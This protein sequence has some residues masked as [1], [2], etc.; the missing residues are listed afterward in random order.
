M[1]FYS[2]SYSEALDLPLRTFWLMSNNIN[3]ISAE[4]D[5]RR[6]S[7]MAAASSSEGFGKAQ[8]ALQREM[9]EVFGRAAADTSDLPSEMEIRRGLAT[10]KSL[11]GKM[12]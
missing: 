2:M 1:H 4:A 3:R 12:T 5:I 10:L 11:A 8:E 9:G 6:L 7:I